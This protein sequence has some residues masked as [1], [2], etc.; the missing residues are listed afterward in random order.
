[1]I[2]K[3]YGQNLCSEKVSARFYKL[4]RLKKR[5][6]KLVLLL[7]GHVFSRKRDR[8]PYLELNVKEDMPLIFRM[9]PRMADS[10]N[11]LPFADA[12]QSVAV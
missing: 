5:T 2:Y 7:L 4:R 3:V 1:V 9:I 10:S 8:Q 12:P 6:D 11:G